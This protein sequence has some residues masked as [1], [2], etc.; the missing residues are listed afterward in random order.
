MPENNSAPWINWIT[1]TGRRL[2]ILAM[3]N[4]VWGVA[5][6][7]TAPLIIASQHWLLGLTVA[8]TS[9]IIIALGLMVYLMAPALPLDEPQSRP[10]ENA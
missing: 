3:L 10:A 4:V 6:F 5:G 9:A 7:V 2:Q 1:F 8:V